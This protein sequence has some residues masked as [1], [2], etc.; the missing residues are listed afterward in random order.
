MYNVVSFFIKHKS[1]TFDNLRYKCDLNKIANE[2]VRKG[3]YTMVEFLISK[4]VYPTD[5]DKLVKLNKPE[6]INPELINKFPP[7]KESLNKAASKGNREVLEYLAQ[8]NRLPTVYGANL[9]AIN[10]HTNVIEL[11]A[12]HSIYP[13]YYGMNG[14]CK[15]GHIEIIKLLAA[16]NC[17][18]S[19]K[20][21]DLALK[22]GHNDIVEFLDTL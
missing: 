14:A 9:A 7:S 20:G 3:D 22:H 11:L 5:L 12:Q 13:D 1:M 2:A 15:H 10:G 19:K 21:M 8:H 16:H 4:G 17:I 6:Y 18:P